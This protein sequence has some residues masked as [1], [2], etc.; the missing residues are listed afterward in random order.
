[1][2]LKK[3]LVL[4]SFI[5]SIL[6]LTQL[7]TSAQNQ[8]EL[9]SGWKCQKATAVTVNGAQLSKNDFPLGSWQEATVPG[10]VLT[11]QLNNK[12]VPD[13]F[14]GMNNA[15]IPDIYKVGRDYYT[16]W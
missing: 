5:L 10:T 11:T 6:L 15:H 3:Y 14:I 4:A 1:M 9:N 16:Y 8:Y 13:P 7:Q 12:Q 2:S